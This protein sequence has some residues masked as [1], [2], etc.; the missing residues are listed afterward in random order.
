[1]REFQVETIGSGPRVVLVHGSGNA[2]AAWARQRELRE[3][4]T[5][6]LPARTGYPPN[7][8]LERI[9][10]EE[11]AEELRPLLADGAHLVGHSYGGV[12]ALLMAARSTELVHS[13]V[14]SEPPAFGVANGDAEVARLVSG[15]RALFAAG[16]DDPAEHLRR[17]VALVGVE[18]EVPEP[19][20]REAERMVRAAMAERPPWEAEIPFAELRAARIPTLVV[21]GAHH[22]AFEAVCDAL[23]ERLEAKRAVVTGRGHNIPA[24]PGYNEALTA[25]LGAL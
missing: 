2:T 19:M 8:P 15:L 20:P 14:V 5:L 13:L 11:Q 6:V 10:F 1:V 16:L 25:F 22:P 17:F 23:G 18:L 21:S 24:A 7:P 9:D 3:R 4:F 12:I